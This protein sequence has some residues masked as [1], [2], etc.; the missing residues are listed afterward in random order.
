MNYN[1]IA[2]NENKLIEGITVKWIAK[3]VIYTFMKK[4]KGY[5]ILKNTKNKIIKID[6]FTF[7]RK[8]EYIS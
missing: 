1:T 6:Y 8:F 5:V 4:E 7:V 3:N 2:Q